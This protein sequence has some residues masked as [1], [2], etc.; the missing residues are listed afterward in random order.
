MP[1]SW[2]YDSRVTTECGLNR[3]SYCSCWP[4]LN[5]EKSSQ[6]VANEICASPEP[7]CA[8]EDLLSPQRSAKDL[9]FFWVPL[10][11]NGSMLLHHL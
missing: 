7:H 2:R 1:G 10:S 3:L 9:L 6:Q 4:A 5:K 11:H 8:V